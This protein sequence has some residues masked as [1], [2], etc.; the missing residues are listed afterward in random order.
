MANFR[1][2]TGGRGDLKNLVLA[3]NDLATR[4]DALTAKIDADS[5]DTGG[6]AD[7]ASV[8]GAAPTLSG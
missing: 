8:I 5:G 7:Y 2:T 6:D 4:F 3:F 1:L